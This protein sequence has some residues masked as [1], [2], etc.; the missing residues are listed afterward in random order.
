MAASG[1]VDQSAR[2]VACSVGSR[3]AFG[4]VRGWL[5]IAVGLAVPPLIAA[6]Q[7]G[8]VNGWWLAALGVVGGLAVIGLIFLAS[9]IVALV[10]QRNEAR[11]LLNEYRSDDAAR[12]IERL[13]EFVIDRG[14]A[15]LDALRCLTAR[16]INRQCRGFSRRAIRRRSMPEA[17]PYGSQVAQ[18]PSGPVRGTR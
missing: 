3:F 10:L 15:D 2:T 18:R 12:A 8:A 7:F 17:Q 9:L 5:M 1:I 13:Q 6:S 4:T 14:G 16:D 11:K